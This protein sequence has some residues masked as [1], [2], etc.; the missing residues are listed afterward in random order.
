MMTLQ[1]FQDASDAQTP[2]FA[3]TPFGFEHGQN[4]LTPGRDRSRL[5][6]EVLE[7]RVHGLGGGEV[8]MACPDEQFAC[9]KLTRRNFD[10]YSKNYFLDRAEAVA[11]AEE[12][13]QAT[14]TA[15]PGMRVLSHEVILRKH[16]IAGDYEAWKT[17]ETETLARWEEP[18]PETV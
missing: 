1:Q 11:Y 10:A 14:L 2:L 9:H 15:S 3:V 17:E 13:F 16:S 12:Q 4:L 18:K 7:L 8:E 6:T 5:H